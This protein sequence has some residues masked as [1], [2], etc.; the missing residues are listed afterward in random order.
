LKL[1]IALLLSVIPSFG[2]AGVIIDATQFSQSSVSASPDA[3]ETPEPD[4]PQR[5]NSARNMFG[6]AANSVTTVSHSSNAI[7]GWPV[8]FVK[9]IPPVESVHGLGEWLF[10]PDSPVLKIPKVPIV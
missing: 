4:S 3:D 9:T 7:G 8:L 2:M 5:L 1:T 10:V 6:M